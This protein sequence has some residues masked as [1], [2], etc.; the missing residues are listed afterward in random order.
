MLTIVALHDAILLVHHME[1]SRHRLIVRHTL[2]IRALHDALQRIRQHHIVLLHHLIVAYDVYHH[3]RC[4]HSYLVDVGLREEL[5][6]NL[7]D[8]LLSQSQALQIEPMVM[9][10]SICSRP[11]S[12][13][14][15]NSLSAGI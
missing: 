8:T 10:F 15:V 2:R 4:H 3:I 14:T 13:T 5:I 12:D 11:S 6:S 7:D 1:V 9:R